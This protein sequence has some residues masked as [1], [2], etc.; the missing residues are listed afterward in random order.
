MDAMNENQNTASSAGEH[1]LDQLRRL[2]RSRDNKVIAGVCGGL[3]RSL[4]ID[5]L[6]L[7]VVLAVLVLFGGTG[8]VLYAIGWLLLPVDDGTP[9]VG[10]QV[11]GNESPRRTQTVWL[12]IILTV[13]IAVG[14]VGAFG[15]WDGPIL[16]S[17][18]LVGLLVWLLNR[19]PS[20]L[21]AAPSTI[22]SPARAAGSVPAAPPYGTA[23]T[24]Q[25]AASDVS[26]EQA[27]D[28]G[29]PPAYE[30]PPTAE[31]PPSGPG[32]PPQ[33]PYG[34]TP[35][36]PPQPPLPPVPPQPPRPRSH[37]FALTLSVALI[38]LGVLA[39][40]DVAGA[41]P[42][43][44]A[45]PALALTVTGAGLVLGAWFGRARGLVFWGLVLSFVTLVASV[46]GHARGL[47]DESVDQRVT[48][49]TVSQLPTADRYGAGQV[50]Y[51]LTG[52]DLA[53]ASASMSSRIGFGEIV[54]V[55]PRDLD[56]VLDAR[57]AV[58]GLT[59]FG[60]D[61]G[62]VNQRRERT[63]YGDDGPGGGTLDLTLYAGFGHLEVRRAA[64]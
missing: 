47:S 19:Q 20:T 24:V 64:S 22:P 3:G 32:L 53:G 14:V 6:L 17:L 29:L 55:V 27:P 5:P 16:L 15:R 1:V 38:A 2:R 54:V 59:A 8:I 50:E 12:A 28:G 48:V 10:A 58:G 30:L 44:G 57:T 45:Y 40:F 21:P 37:L 61:T 13:A 63:D 42:P 33:P 56:V 7:R 4:G 46:A 26:T 60:S 31:L 18:A 62:G 9:S 25:L 41:A 11:V 36:P 51:D 43:A 39:A 49:T 34:T 23:T 52:L 35:M